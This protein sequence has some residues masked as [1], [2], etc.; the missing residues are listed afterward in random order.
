MASAVK[1]TNNY[2]PAND[3][4]SQTPLYPTNPWANQEGENAIKLQGIKTNQARHAVAFTWAVASAGAQVTFTPSTGATTAT[5]Y[6][7]FTIVDQSGNEAFATGF[8]ASAATTARAVNTTALNKND[9]WKVYFSTSNGG[10][11][12]KVDFTFEISTGAIR[13]NASATVSYANLP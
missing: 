1:N 10:G 9:D 8:Q 12:T 5:D 6:Q 2:S 4:V 7:K 13:G 3:Y 11:A